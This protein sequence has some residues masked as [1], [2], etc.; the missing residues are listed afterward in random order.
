MKDI[1]WIM[2]G[3]AEKYGQAGEMWILDLKTLIFDFRNS[4]VWSIQLKATFSSLYACLWVVV[5]INVTLGRKSIFLS[6]FMSW[7]TIKMWDIDK[8]SQIIIIIISKPENNSKNICDV[9]MWDFSKRYSKLQA[10]SFM[11]W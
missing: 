1:K 6:S 4:T 7:M 3:S 9:Y 11:L 10:C 8:H 2:V 5:Y